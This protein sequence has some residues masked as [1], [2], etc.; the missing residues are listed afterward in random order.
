MTER[1]VITE[2]CI[3]KLPRGVKLRHDKARDAWVLLAPER[4]FMPDP[5]AVEIL[6]RCTGQV[7]LSGVIDDLAETYNAPRD[8]IAKD[9]VAMLQDLAD[10][11]MVEV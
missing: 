1:A 7:A 3:A 10:K 9:V 4:V 11:G 8:Q 2:D 5:I 6:K